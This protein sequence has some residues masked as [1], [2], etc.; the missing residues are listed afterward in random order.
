MQWHGLWAT[1]LPVLYNLPVQLYRDNAQNKPSGVH[2]TKL[3]NVRPCCSQVLSN[4]GNVCMKLRYALFAL[5]VC[6]KMRLPQV[7]GQLRSHHHRRSLA[8]WL[9][10]GSELYIILIPSKPSSLECS[11]VL[12]VALCVLLV[13]NDWGM[14]QHLCV[15]ECGGCALYS[16][17]F[18]RYTP[19]HSFG[20]RQ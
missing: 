1:M 11:H 18:T 20:S 5:S 13:H 12:C 7:R 2:T 16:F 19:T 17:S 14:Q 9:T 3:C 15:P 8:A 6:R 10:R 4:P